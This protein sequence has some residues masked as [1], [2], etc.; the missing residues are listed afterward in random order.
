MPLTK[1]QE[2]AL[3]GDEKEWKRLRELELIEGQEPAPLTFQDG[4]EHARNLKAIGQKYLELSDSEYQRIANS[5]V[6]KPGLAISPEQEQ[7]IK[8]YL[9]SGDTTAAKQVIIDS[10]DEWSANNP[11]ERFLGTNDELSLQLPAVTSFGRPDKSLTC[12][13]GTIRKFFPNRGYG[14]IKPDIDGL[15]VWIHVNNCVEGY[16][17]KEGDKV[18]YLT[19]LGKEGLIAKEVCIIQKIFETISESFPQPMLEHR[20]EE[21]SMYDVIYSKR[22]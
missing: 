3:N 19:R 12:S 5:P 15:D 22:S 21:Q 2:A 18:V 17:P 11:P 1:L 9:E 4:Q 10:L 16:R 7:L 8:S 13:T 20:E 6:R 14:F